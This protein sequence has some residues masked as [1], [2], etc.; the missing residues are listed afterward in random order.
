MVQRQFTY[1]GKTV[2]E[3]KDLSLTELSMIL[4]SDARRKI[5]RLTLADKKFINKVER[6]IKPVKTQNRDMII[7][8]TF[9]GKTIAI[10]TGKEYQQIMIMPEMIGHWLGEYALTRRKVAHNAPGIGATRSSASASVK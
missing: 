2:E 3:L 4:K 8:P 7:L 5:R 9:V 10:H 6:S 1:K